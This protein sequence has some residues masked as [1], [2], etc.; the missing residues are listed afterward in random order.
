MNIL[1]TGANGYIGN[2]L[3]LYSTRQRHRIWGVV[4]PSCEPQ[5]LEILRD[6]GVTIVR[7]DLEGNSRLDV[8]AGEVQVVVHLVGSLHPP[9]AGTFRSLHEG[10]TRFLTSECRRL[11]VKKLVYLGTLGAAP[12]GKSEYLRTKWL[13]EEEVRASGLDYVILRAPLIFGKSFGVRESKV[14]TRLKELIK[15]SSRIPILGSGK[16]LLQPLYIGDLVQYLEKA[17]VDPAIRDETIDLGGPERLP[18]EQLID[19]IAQSLHVRKAKIKIPFPLAFLIAFC[20]ERFSP[21]PSITLDEVR[22]MRGDVICQSDK[23]N[24]ML[25]PPKVPL[26]DGI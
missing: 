26:K 16:N 18:F 2:H 13:A 5:D 8:K 6:L 23:M 4:R 10:K 12:D 7:N 22:M 24:K 14:M 11:G 1:V 19:T 21:E 3:L 20:M 25:G 9:Q 17:A 15:T